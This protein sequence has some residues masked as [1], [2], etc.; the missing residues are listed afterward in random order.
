ME[1]IPPIKQEEVQQDLEAEGVPLKTDEEAANLDLDE[2]ELLLKLRLIRLKRK[3][4]QAKAEQRQSS[5]QS[6]TPSITRSVSTTSEHQRISTTSLPIHPGPVLIDLLS[7][8]EEPHIKLEANHDSKSKSVPSLEPIVPSTEDTAMTGVTSELLSEEGRARSPSR[9]RTEESLSMH[10]SRDAPIRGASEDQAAD[11]RA[12]VPSEASKT[13]MLAPRSQPQV[14]GPRK[15]LDKLKIRLRTSIPNKPISAGTPAP[16]LQ[17]RPTKRSTLQQKVV[18]EPLMK[19][20]KKRLTRKEQLEQ[21]AGEL[22]D[23][24]STTD[25]YIRDPRT[26]PPEGAYSFGLTMDDT[27]RMLARFCLR[28][29]EYICSWL[30]LTGE[31]AS[32]AEV[33]TLLSPIRQRVC[34]SGYASIEDLVKDVGSLIKIQVFGGCDEPYI[35]RYLQEQED[36]WRNCQLLCE[37]ERDD[38]KRMGIVDDWV[39]LA[40]KG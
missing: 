23:S 27:Q 28:T 24:E 35:R 32:T 17:H 19:P 18:T 4:L 40:E 6:A 3:R 29:M 8:D 16:P 20:R 26:R 31:A 15:K 9:Q 39:V 34:A 37:Q 13:T 14:R 33:T 38:E 21:E 2:E 36:N 30:C 1:A 5:A 25:V 10:R 22:R 12:S 7:D 11:H